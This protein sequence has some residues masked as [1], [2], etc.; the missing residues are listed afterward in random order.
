MKEGI[1]YENINKLLYK[2]NNI[3]N[4][5]SLYKQQK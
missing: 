2:Y 1:I 5:H 3:R 4:H